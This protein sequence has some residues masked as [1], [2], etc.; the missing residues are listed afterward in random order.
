MYKTTTDTQSARANSK[1]LA[2]TSYD[3]SDATPGFRV[4]VS[5]LV[6]RGNR[7]GQCLTSYVPQ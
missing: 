1:G 2:V 6:Q 7:Q 4:K 3:V 5:V